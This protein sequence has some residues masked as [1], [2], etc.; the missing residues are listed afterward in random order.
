MKNTV[1]LSFFLSVSLT[2]TCSAATIIVHADGSGDYPT[3][4][5]AID[6]A[7]E[8]DTVEVWP[9]TYTGD[10]NRDIDPNGK[11]LTLLVHHQQ[12][13]RCHLPA[14]CYIHKRL[15]SLQR[16]KELIFHTLCSFVRLNQLY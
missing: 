1:M 2:F 4:Q 10:G 9:G 7:N 13:M 3:I 14:F 15:R 16:A 8:G 12:Q 5:A 11:N 6:A